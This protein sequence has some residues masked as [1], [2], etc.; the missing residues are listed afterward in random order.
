M[1]TAT[2]SAVSGALFALGLVVSGMTSP[3]KVVGFLDVFG[4]WDPSLAF[5]MIGAI[6]VHALLYRL[7][8][9]RG[10]L[11]GIKLQVPRRRE[12]DL[13]LVAGAALFGVGWG[14]GG[15]C[16]G[17]GLVGMMSG[18]AP[19]LVFVAAML[20]GMTLFSIWEALRGE[21]ANPKT[22]TPT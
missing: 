12:I 16:P 5:V 10:P 2:F 9:K 11:G 22:S 8:V 1:K 21:A 7:I 13:R 6:G 4:A 17:P 20:G 18:T 3:Q 15:V 19:F 14:L